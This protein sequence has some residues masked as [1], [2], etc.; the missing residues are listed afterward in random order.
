[1]VWRAGLWQKLLKY[2]LKGRCFT[3]ILSMYKSIKSCVIVNGEQSSFFDC[4]SGVRQGENLSPILFALF[5][6]DL[7]SFMNSSGL[8]GVCLTEHNKRNDAIVYLKLLLL[9]YADDTVIFSDNHQGLQKALDNLEVYC[10]IWKLTVN[11]DKTKVVVFERRKSKNK[12]NFYFNGKKVDLVESFKYL[13]IY[14]N[15]KGTFTDAKKH[16]TEQASKAMISLLRKWKQFDIPVDLMLDLFDKSV[17]PILLYGCEVWGY[18]NVDMIERIHLRFCK[19][20]LG[21]KKSTANYLVY[22][23]LWQ[24][25]LNVYMYAR[26][27]KF[28]AKIVS[29]E[30]HNRISHILYQIQLCHFYRNKNCSW[31]RIVKSKLETLGFADIWQFQ[32]FPHAQWLF[33][34]MKQRLKDQFIQNWISSLNTHKSSISE[35][36]KSFKGSFHMEHYLSLMSGN[37]KVL[38]TKLRFSL[39]KFPVVTGRYEGIPYDE[40]HCT[41][42]NTNLIG[43]EF[44]YLLVCKKFQA[45]REKYI[46]DY[47]WKYPKEYKL[48]SLLQSKD[49]NLLNKCCFVIRFILKN[50]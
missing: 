6:N 40:R 36:Y 35:Y 14:F 5:L 4:N 1:M 7:E 2:G 16:L 22:G 24:F 39:L 13:C 23:E 18:E 43:N 31:I 47:F 11:V 32:N 50:F 21:V 46:P 48:V 29:P 17:T 44:H 33:L 10:K 8:H 26:L 19:I 49:L 3:I 27:I 9:L 38:F 15:S 45:I 28:W 25:P 34:T 42:C 37:N 41:F 20:L 30:N 12:Y